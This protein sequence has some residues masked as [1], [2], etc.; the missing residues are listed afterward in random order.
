MEFS[1]VIPT[2]PKHHKFI[3]SL[4]NTFKNSDYVGEILII[5]SSTRNIEASK[6]GSLIGRLNM[7]VS[8]QI[9]STKQKRTA[10]E[11]R[12]FGW[13]I[14]RS[15]YIMFLDAD[16]WY[17]IKRL[18]VIAEVIQKTNADL[19]IHNYWKVKPR[20]FLR[21]KITLNANDWLGSDELI[22]ATWEQGIRSV[23][24]E[25][26]IKGDTNVI[27]RDKNGNLWPVQHGHVT[28]RRSVPLRF[29][30]LRYGEDGRMIR[31]ALEK[32][33][34]VIYIPNKLSIYNQISL[35][36]VVRSSFRFFKRLLFRQ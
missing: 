30:S 29:S 33:Y 27:A 10:G 24:M 11:N 14:A 32:G 26:G 19:V 18:E 20:W 22:A 34:S 13:E 16:D 12:N 3:P 8:P 1:I 9:E 6:L 25:L 17:S 4:I 15:E 5:S 23:D 7:K 2:T 28:I 21:K 36:F 31:D 35:E